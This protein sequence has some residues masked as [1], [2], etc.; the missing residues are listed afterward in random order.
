MRGEGEWKGKTEREIE[1]KKK[2]I[3]HTKEKEDRMTR[4][5]IESKRKSNPG[6]GEG[7]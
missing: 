4:H 1:E 5:K 6:D 3:L 7:G 2:K